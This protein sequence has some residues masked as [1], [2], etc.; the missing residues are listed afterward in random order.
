MRVRL[1]AEQ[2]REVERALNLRD[3]HGALVDVVNVLVK[4]LNSHLHLR[5][6][7]C[8]QEGE[9][10]RRDQ[11]RARFDHQAHHAVRCLLVAHVFAFKLIE[12][13]VLMLRDRLPRFARFVEVHHSFVVGE[14]SFVDQALLRLCERNK[15]IP[16]IAQP[17]IAIELAAFAG[18][19]RRKRCCR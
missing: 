2:A 19:R 11:A 4:A 10:L 15:I 14:L 16:F 12:R 7:K 5:C 17:A 9:V 6:T 18:V 8:T 3:A 1:E 13:G